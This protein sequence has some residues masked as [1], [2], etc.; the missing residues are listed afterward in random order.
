[1]KTILYLHSGAELYGADQILLNLVCNLDKE[2]FNP[3]VVLPCDGP[4]VEIL[5]KNNIET[6]II[7]YP[8]VRRKYFNFKGIFSYLFGY[9][10]SV[11]QIAKFAK[12]KHVDLIHNNTIAVLEG[13]AVSKKIHKPL[14]THV[15]EMIDKPTI[16]SKILYNL[17]IK[18]SNKVITVSKS[19]K[20]HIENITKN[21]KKNIEVVYNGIKADRFMTKYNIDY[22][23]KEFN[24]PKDK[25]FILGTIGRINA[26]KGQEDFID[27]VYE[28]SRKNNNIYGIIVGDAFSGQEWRIEKLKKKIKDLNLEEN[29]KYVGFRKD[30]A[31]LHQFFDIYVLPSIQK[32]SFPTVVLESMATGNPILAYKCGGVEEMLQ[33]NLN[34]YLVELGNKKEMINKILTIIKDK[35]K[36]EIMKQKSIEIFYNNFTIDKF[37]KKIEKIYLEF[38][39]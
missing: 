24:I 34:G 15:H 25:S 27:I 29:I 26:I 16:V 35:Q 14:I 38:G 5:N 30:I 2:S 13:I 28:L 6:K 32:D 33:D 17:L 31:E 9:F 3:I 20:N 37:I 12:E 19:V 23:Y 4:L 21:K 11:K 8:I 10:S 36:C 18:N 7:K 1:M 39:E 22:L